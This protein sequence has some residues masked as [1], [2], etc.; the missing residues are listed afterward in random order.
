MVGPQT[1]LAANPAKSNAAPADDL[2]SF[3]SKHVTEKRSF[4]VFK[5][6]TCVVINEPC[7]DPM[8]E[9]HNILAT[10]KDA[11]CPFPD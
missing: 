4:V 6:G 3:C 2:V 5:R 11:E 8:T 1:D 9:A 10:C 7:A